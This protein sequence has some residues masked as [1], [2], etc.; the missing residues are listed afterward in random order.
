MILEFGAFI[1]N[2]KELSRNKR[3]TG[4]LTAR[5]AENLCPSC[6]SQGNL[7]PHD[8]Y[9]RNLIHFYKGRV[10]DCVF[11]IKRFICSSCTKTHALIPAGVVPYSYY[12][13]EFVQSLM[14]LVNKGKHSRD[15]L[16]EI[17]HISQT[18]YYRLKRCFYRHFKLWSSVLKFSPWIKEEFF[19]ALLS[20]RKEASLFLK[21]FFLTFGI[22]FLQQRTKTTKYYRRL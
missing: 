11:F 15:K 2:N 1:N 22:S 13:I 8:Q 16:C 21:S 20:R 4:F 6:G 17:F 3:E 7:K 5:L 12:S 19:L 14:K 18:T 9:S 10:V